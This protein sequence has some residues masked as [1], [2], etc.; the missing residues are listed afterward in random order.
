M[1]G[2]DDALARIANDPAWADAV[3]TNPTDALRGFDLGPDE[4][5]R[6]EHALGTHPGP[7]AAIFQAPP[8][9]ATPAAAVAVVSGCVPAVGVVR[10]RLPNSSPTVCPSPTLTVALAWVV[11]SSEG[12]SV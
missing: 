5:A 3:R 12:G 8:A 1:A 9:V 7:P 6:L 10:I 2:L 11:I 4:L